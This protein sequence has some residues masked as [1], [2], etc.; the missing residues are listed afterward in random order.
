MS[1]KEV[2]T[3]FEPLIGLPCWNVKPGYGSFLTLEFGEPELDIREP[4]HAPKCRQKVRKRLARRSV[5][6]H[7][8]WHLWIYCCEWQVITKGKVVGHSDL[9]GSTK[10]WI[11][12]AADELNGQKLTGFR[13]K[14][15][16][17]SSTFEFDMGSS[18]QTKP[19]NKRSNQWLLYEPDGRVLTYR[20]DGRFSHHPGDLPPGEEVWRSIT[21]LE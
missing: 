20:A 5:V 17:G 9:A 6:V 18:L 11:K 19:Y 15:K 10:K 14:P 12:R 4:I 2:H 13:I 1:K 21:R 7:G 3:S 8:R 16:R